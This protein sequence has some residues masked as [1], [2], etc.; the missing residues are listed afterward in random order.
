MLHTVTLNL[1]VFVWVKTNVF[2]Q[3]MMTNAKYMSGLAAL[4]LLEA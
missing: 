4:E 2:S 1:I 3:K